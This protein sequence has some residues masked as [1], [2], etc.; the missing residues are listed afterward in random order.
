MWLAETATRWFVL[1]SL[2][3]TNVLND[4]TAAPFLVCFSQLPAVQKPENH[5]AVTLLR[6]FVCSNF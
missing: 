1:E 3:H 2:L 4:V 5:A 6:R